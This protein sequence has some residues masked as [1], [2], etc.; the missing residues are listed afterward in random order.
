MNQSLLSQSFNPVHPLQQ[1]QQTPRSVSTS[2]GFPQQQQHQQQHS[3]QSQLHLIQQQQQQQH[4]LSHF[5]GLDGSQRMNPHSMN[6]P[7]A[8]ALMDSPAANTIHAQ[9]QQHF[10]GL[11]QDSPLGPLD[12]SSNR[13]NDPVNNNNKGPEMFHI[14]SPPLTPSGVMARSPSSY[15]TFGMNNSVKRPPLWPMDR[16][17]VLPFPRQTPTPSQ[18]SKGN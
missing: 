2:N 4:Q 12:H 16:P 7:I 6:S 5:Q 10:H 18:S 3:I 17:I 9:Q 1:Q 13:W 14:T 8:S 11:C 15:N